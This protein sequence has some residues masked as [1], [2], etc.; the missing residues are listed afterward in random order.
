MAACWTVDV[1]GKK[2]AEIKLEGRLQPTWL[3][4]K[5]RKN[6]VNTEHRGQPSGL[7]QQYTAHR[8]KW[9]LQL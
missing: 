6:T 5:Q 9:E 3:C 4:L 2:Q 7:A 1:C 8:E